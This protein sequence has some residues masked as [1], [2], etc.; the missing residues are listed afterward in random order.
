MHST[1]E[2]FSILENVAFSL[3]EVEVS[4]WDA[5][6]LVLAQTVCSPIN[7]PPFRQSNVDGFAL[8]LHDGLK[9]SIVGEIKAGD[10]RFIE[11]QPGEAVKIFT[12]AAVPDS[13]QAVVPIE[14]AICTNNKL[15][16]EELL[17]PE[18]NIRALGS[19]I[20]KNAVALE[21][22]TYLNAA[23]IGFLTGLGLTSV[24]VYPKPKVGIVITG[25]E[26][27]AAG[28]PL[29][30]GKVYESNGI[31]L[32]AALY[33]DFYEALTL[34]DVADN[35]DET[36]SM[37]R[38]ALAENDLLVVSG[39]ISVG[40]HDYVGRALESLGATPLFYKVNQKP[41]KPLWV[42]Q[43][44]EKLI[45]ALPGNPAAGLTCLYIYV[46]PTLDKLSGIKTEY[47]ASLQKKLTHDYSVCNLRCQFLK[48]LISGEGATILPHQD[49]AM[50]NSFALANGLVYLPEGNYQK[51]TGDN[52]EVYPI[53]KLK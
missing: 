30:Y 39:G 1:T 2:A 34:Y 43:W 26:L 50:L 51:I 12:G 19:Q 23:A 8:A 41:G 46:L 33:Q 44:E 52:V 24:K 38:N 37:L 21:I 25:N 28:L 35:L 36:T 31:M 27:V 3:K 42:G 29:P 15:L 45:F 6:H 11:L 5:R 14:K 47:T 7:M 40:D 48:A 17:L 9:Y 4:L 53:Q 13:A 49:S 10:E 18:T 20:V 32:K 22:G 16:T